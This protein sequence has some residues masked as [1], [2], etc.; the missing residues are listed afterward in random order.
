MTQTQYL[1][2]SVTCLRS[3]LKNI[4]ELR[5]EYGPGEHKHY[6]RLHAITLGFAEVGMC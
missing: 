1:V 5:M 2:C 6:L 3:C 4:D